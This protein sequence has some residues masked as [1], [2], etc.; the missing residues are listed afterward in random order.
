MHKMRARACVC[1]C[2]SEQETC[3]EQPAAC[4]CRLHAGPTQTDRERLGTRI[5]VT[6]ADFTPR[7]SLMSAPI[8]F[9]TMARRS[10]ECP[11][12]YS[13]LFVQKLHAKAMQENCEESTFKCEEAVVQGA[14]SIMACVGAPEDNATFFG[15]TPTIF[16]GNTGYAGVCLVFVFVCERAV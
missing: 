7:S 15:L 16:N 1:A 6:K 10:A 4:V 8:R 9:Q 3:H 5:R 13:S 11:Y 14:E 12:N 2:V